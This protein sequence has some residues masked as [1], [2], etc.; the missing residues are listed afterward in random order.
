MNA[1]T[2]TI[3]TKER[4]KFEKYIN[5]PI[6]QKLLAEYSDSVLRTSSETAIAALGILYAD[7]NNTN[8]DEDFKRF[9]CFALQGG[10]EGLIEAFLVLSEIEP[11]TKGGPYPVCALTQEVYENNDNI[12]S[13]IESAEDAFAFIHELIRRGCFLPDHFTSRMHGDQ[14]FVHFGVT[15]TSIELSNLLLKAKSFLHASALPG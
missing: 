5:S 7:T 1:A 8:Y 13:V 6:G 3:S 12:N 11:E 14:W 10:T 4:K 9:A 15:E 2:D